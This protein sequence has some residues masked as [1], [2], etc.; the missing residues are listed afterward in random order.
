MSAWVTYLLSA[1]RAAAGLA[2]SFDV[3]DLLLI[4]GRRCRFEITGVRLTETVAQFAGKMW[5][6]L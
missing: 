2:G 3:A 5:G 6:S 1:R 4:V